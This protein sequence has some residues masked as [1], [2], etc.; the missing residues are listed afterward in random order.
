MTRSK[1]GKGSEEGYEAEKF[2]VRR[3]KSATMANE[4]QYSVDH[5]KTDRYSFKLEGIFDNVLLRRNL[6]NQHR[7]QEAF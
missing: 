3:N 7:I 2:N 5:W 6:C 4:I 1:V